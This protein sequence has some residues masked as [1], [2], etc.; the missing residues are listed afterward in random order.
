MTRPARPA[1]P[2]APGHKATGPIRPTA[3][4][5]DLDGT[6]T[7]SAPVILRSFAGALTELGIPVP[8]HETLMTFVGPPLSETFRTYAGLEGEANADAVTRYRRHYREHMLEAPLYNGAR[9]IVE[10]LHRAGIATSLAT[11]KN[12]SLARL[13]VEHWGLLPQLTAVS[14]A[15]EAD[16]D[17]SKAAVIRR[18]LARLEAAGADLSTVVHVGDRHHDVDGAHEA[19]VGCVGILWGYGD[20][21]ELAEAEW[22]AATP[23]ELLALLG[24]DGVESRRDGGQSR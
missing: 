10:A 1:T 21:A 3:V 20:A 4:L 19:G 7:D 11:S 16:R 24:V 15:D 23:G 22:L 8:D 9:E 2:E 6:I 18:A 13:I 14:G 17:G 12:E 5:L